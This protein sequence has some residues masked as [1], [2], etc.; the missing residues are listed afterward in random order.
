MS[1]GVAAAATVVL[2]ILLIPR[3]GINGAAVASSCAYTVALLMSLSV[4]RRSTG[5]GPG[6]ADR[7][8]SERPRAA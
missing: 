7:A 4:Y 2:D 6:G 5:T 3:F 8:P 1:A